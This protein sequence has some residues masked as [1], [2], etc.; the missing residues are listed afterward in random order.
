MPIIGAVPMPFAV[1]LVSILIGYLLARLLG[2]HAGWVGRRWARGVRASVGESIHDEVIQRG[3]APLDRLE[4]ARR[5][6]AF[7][8]ADVLRGCARG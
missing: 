5:R 3:L 6:L 4:E 2:L 7:S 8:T 1:L